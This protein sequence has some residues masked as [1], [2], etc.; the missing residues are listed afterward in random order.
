MAWNEL[1]WLGK[2]HWTF[3]QMKS[4]WTWMFLVV[5]ASSDR[6]RWKQKW[7]KIDLGT[8][9]RSICDS[10]YLYFWQPQHFKFYFRFLICIKFMHSKWNEFKAV[11]GQRGKVKLRFSRYIPQHSCQQQAEKWLKVLEGR[12]IE[13]PNAFKEKVFCFIESIQT[14]KCLTAPKIVLNTT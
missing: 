12:S 13:T 4:I 11:K 7:H 9:R 3:Q 5:T 10:F 6:V 8:E 14:W 2:G 1:L